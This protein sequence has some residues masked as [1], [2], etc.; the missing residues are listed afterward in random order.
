MAAICPEHADRTVQGSCTTCG[1]FG[2]ELCL[3]EINGADHCKRCLGARVTRP[4]RHTS[5][6][7]R[8]VLS[9]AP[10]VGH[11]Y[12]GLMNRGLQL[13]VLSVIG[14]MMLSAVN[15]VLFAFFI[16][17]TVFYSIFD[18]REAHLRMRVGEN[19]P[20]V[21]LVNWGIFTTQRW[22]AYGLVGLGILGIY[23]ALTY[24][25]L[26]WAARHQFPDVWRG[27][28]R[29]FEGSLVGALAILLGLWMLRRGFQ[30]SDS[31][32]GGTDQ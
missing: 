1:R 2:C 20:D 32:T 14:S 16:V 3:V 30:R 9:A 18:A 26:T 5:G 31:G 19:V 11:M 12:L 6:F 10:G 23:R 15:D 27:M 13:M 7:M 24:E 22:I 28:I 17:G 25:F 21:L 4:E 8:L 29:A